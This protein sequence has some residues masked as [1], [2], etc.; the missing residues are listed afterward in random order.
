QGISQTTYRIPVR[1]HRPTPLQI[2]DRPNTQTRPMRQLLLR[3]ERRQPA[4]A[5]PDT[6]RRLSH[7][8]PASPPS[9]SST[10]RSPPCQERDGA[11]VSYK[12]T[13]TGHNSLG[14]C[15]AVLALRLPDLIAGLV[16]GGS[17]A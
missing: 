10:Q 2:T 15:G 8:A 9:P 16:R 5:E 3:Q 6:K 13:Q 4:R 1:A 7:T 12:C 11:L 14:T 17:G